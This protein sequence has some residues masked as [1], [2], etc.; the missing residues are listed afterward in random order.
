VKRGDLKEL[1]YISPLENVRSI[2]IRGIYCYERAQRL[3]HRSF[4]MTEVQEIRHAKRVPGG[5]RLHAYVNLYICAQ[6]ATLYKIHD[7]HEDLCVLRVSTAVLDRPGVVISDRNAATNAR[8]TDSPGGLD[9]IDPRIVFARTWKHPGDPDV[10]S[11][12]RKARSAEV[13]VPERVP[14]AFVFGAYVSCR[15]S[16]AWLQELA[17]GLSVDV[18]PGFF[19]LQDEAW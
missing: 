17:P 9:L 2:L 8:F 14:G 11:R 6:N 12:H 4:A 3:E 19:F 15:Q 18:H 13:L 5:L 10:E 1:H 16:K 7:R